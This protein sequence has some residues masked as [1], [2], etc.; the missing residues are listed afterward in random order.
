MAR[1]PYEVLGVPKG[2]SEEEVKRAYRR[3]AKQ[4]HPD[5]NPGD[6]TAAQKM[7]EINEAY[8]RIKNPQTYQQ[9]VP[10][11]GA[12]PYGGPNQGTYTYYTYS[13]NQNANFND[14]FEEFIR[15]AQSQQSNQSQYQYHGQDQ[16]GTHYTYRSRRR[17]FSFLRLILLV[18]LLVN[19]VSC[20]GRSLFYSFACD[21]Y[22][23]ARYH[24]YY[25]QQYANN[26]HDSEQR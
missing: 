6:P 24:T 4:Y 18:I 3:L 14:F 12:N 1:D 23:D 11:P 26:F 17:P 16:T 21:P 19:L 13:S 5:I 9:S 2:A 8:D 22:Y 10:K 20:M 7:N 25:T 15:N